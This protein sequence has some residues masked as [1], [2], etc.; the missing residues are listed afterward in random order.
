MARIRYGRFD[1]AGVVMIWRKDVCSLSRT[2]EYHYF[3]DMADHAATF[4]DVI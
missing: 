3:D 2:E 4:V 1:R